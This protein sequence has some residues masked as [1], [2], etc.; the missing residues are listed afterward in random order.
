M[1]EIYPD[2]NGNGVP[3]AFEHRP[4]ISEILNA[5]DIQQQKQAEVDIAN[6]LV[7]ELE[8]T[9]RAARQGEMFIFLDKVEVNRLPFTRCG[10]FWIVKRVIAAPSWWKPE[11]D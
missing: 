3:D 7:L 1:A 5:D 9:P 8:T 4:P 2:T 6:S 11:E 10:P